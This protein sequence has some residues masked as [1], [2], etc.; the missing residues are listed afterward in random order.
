MN[1]QLTPSRRITPDEVFM[2][3]AIAHLVSSASKGSPAQHLEQRHGEDPATRCFLTLRSA[4]NP[5]MT[6]ESAW[7]VALA[8]DAT[9]RFVSSLA[10]FSAA[11]RLIDQGARISLSGRATAI[12]PRRQG[13]VGTTPFVLEGAAAPA[14]SMPIEN[15]TIGPPKKLSAFVVVTREIAQNPSRSSSANAS[16]CDTLRLVACP[17]RER[18]LERACHRMRILG[19]PLSQKLFL[20]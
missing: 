10:D 2:R 6:T 1:Q 13:A 17:S 7:A 8:N 20:R 18:L 16:H 11:S 4:V 9:S 5:I 19:V 3:A 15:V 12:I 14:A